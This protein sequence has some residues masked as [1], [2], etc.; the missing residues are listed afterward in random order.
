MDHDETNRVDADWAM[1]REYDLE[2][3]GGINWP[4]DPLELH[5]GVRA[6]HIIIFALFGVQSG[7]YSE[8]FTPLMFAFEGGFPRLALKHSLHTYTIS[9]PEFILSFCKVYICTS[10]LI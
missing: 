9:Y 10:V 4:R 7:K 6:F 1:G 5:C 2:L 3:G 8:S